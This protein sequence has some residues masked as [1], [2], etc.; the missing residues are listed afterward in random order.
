MPRNG[1]KKENKS[2]LS[3]KTRSMLKEYLKSD[4][5]LYNHF[6]QIFK[7]KMENFGNTHLSNEVSDLEKANTEI[8]KTCSVKATDNALL[9]GDEKWW[10]PNLIG[11]SV[12]NTTNEECRLMTMSELKFIGRIRKKQAA[13][14]A[15]ILENKELEEVAIQK[16]RRDTLFF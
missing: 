8:S 14:A 7:S 16:H 2:Q 11:Y 6:Y 15:L 13:K 10:G 9:Q 4:Y 5:L 3:N 12:Q 1:S